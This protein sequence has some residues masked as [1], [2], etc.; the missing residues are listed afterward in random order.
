[1]KM[2]KLLFV[3]LFGLMG[4]M[5]Q[6]ALGCKDLGEECEVAGDCCDNHACRTNPFN[7]LSK[8]QC[9]WRM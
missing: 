4:S 5:S 8:L 9:R 2:K 1:M 7:P 3:V 6:M